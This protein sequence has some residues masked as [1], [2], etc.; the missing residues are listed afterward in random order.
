MFLDDNDAIF[1]IVIVF[2]LQIVVT[3]NHNLS[4][5]TQIL[6]KSPSSADVFDLIKCHSS[7]WDEF[8]SE[9]RVP[10]NTRESL[11]HNIALE[12]GGRLERVVVKWIESQCSPVTWENIVHMLV[13]MDLKTTAGEVMDYL[14]RRQVIDKSQS[15]QLYT[16]FITPCII[17]KHLFI[18]SMWIQHVIPKITEY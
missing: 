14:K 10:F 6:K 5:D 2:L 11:R 12:D 17:P 16:T 18:G 13:S 9:L 15:K 8:G 1:G 4:D 7:R 3:Y